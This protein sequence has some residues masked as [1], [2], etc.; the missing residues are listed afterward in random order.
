MSA[1]RLETVAKRLRSTAGSLDG[2]QDDIDTMPE[3]ERGNFVGLL[4]ILSALSKE[5][6]GMA[7]DV[8]DR[9]RLLQS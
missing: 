5:V 9:A 6:H 4:V 8:M 3:C 7:S 2:L 1:K